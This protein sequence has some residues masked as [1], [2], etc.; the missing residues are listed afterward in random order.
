M[1]LRDECAGITQTIQEEAKSGVAEFVNSCVEKYFASGEVIKLS[2]STLPF[3]PNELN[4]KFDG[5][6]FVQCTLKMV[7]VE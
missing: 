2:V 3:E 5:K 7:K 1:T 6:T 4:G